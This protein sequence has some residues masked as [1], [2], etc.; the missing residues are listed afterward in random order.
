MVTS[1]CSV[2][3]Q[4]DRE[5]VS[6]LW[7]TG[8]TTKS[9]SVHQ[10]GTYWL[11]TVN[12]FGWQETDTI[13]VKVNF[14]QDT[15]IC[16]GDSVLWDFTQDYPYTF[17]WSNGQNGTFAESGAGD[18]NVLL[19]DTANCTYQQ[20]FTIYV[21]SL[22]YLTSITNVDSLCNGN[23]I[24]LSYPQETENYHVVWSTGDSNSLHTIFTQTGWYGVQVHDSIGCIGRD[25]I[26]VIKKGNAPLVSFTAENIIS[27]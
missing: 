13:E 15:L 9:I 5:Y 8:D 12:R 20:N 23:S 18:Y 22:P 19:T 4:P 26:Y 3:L 7:S 10:S 27:L 6:Y 25:S 17:Q 1:L 16:Y 21:D 2:I 24:T 14:I 11:T